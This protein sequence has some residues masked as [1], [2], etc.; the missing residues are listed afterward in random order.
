[1][2]PSDDS[3]PDS[4]RG[5]TREEKFDRNTIELL[6]EL[7][8]ASTGI[9]FMFA[10]LLVVPFNNAFSKISS[11]EKTVYFI[12]LLCV[13]ISAVLLLAPSIHY[14]I[15]FGQRAKGY[16]VSL[17]NRMAI[18]GMIFLA[19]G[20]TGILILLS[21]FVVGGAAP[22]VVGA[23]AALGIGGL[24]FALPLSRRRR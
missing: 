24:W 14:R 3:A 9:Q 4:G 15:L 20:F 23:A 16:L 17:A 5:E 2:T 13:A 19:F 6:Q 8:V 11:F 10:F 22:V 1:M 21:D 12:T 7:R 18:G